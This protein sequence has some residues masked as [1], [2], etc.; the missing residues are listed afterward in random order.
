M[1]AFNL[2]GF[3]D[4]EV[5]FASKLGANPRLAAPAE[6]TDVPW[7]PKRPPVPHSPH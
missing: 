5:S 2:E 1:T 6:R 4:V 3:P 7:D